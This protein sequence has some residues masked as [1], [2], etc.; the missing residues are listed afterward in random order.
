MFTDMS[1]V[2]TIMPSAIYLLNN[3]HEQVDEQK[4][5]GRHE[6]QDGGGQGK[7]EIVRHKVIQLCRRK[8]KTMRLSKHSWCRLRL[9]S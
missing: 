4:K 3:S 9:E 8:S 5:E 2:S 1:Q 7:R 6:E